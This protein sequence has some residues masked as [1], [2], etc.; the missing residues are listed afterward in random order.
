MPIDSV[1]MA[2]PHN[3]TWVMERRSGAAAA[4]IAEI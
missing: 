4:V 3:S 1:T 2:A